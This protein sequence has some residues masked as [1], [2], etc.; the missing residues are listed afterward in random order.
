V[1]ENVFRGFS[2]KRHIR[3][4]AAAVAGESPE[5]VLSY[6]RGQV[7]AKQLVIALR[8]ASNEGA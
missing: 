1:T 3:G 5:I 4:A 8:G 2:K 7:G 6:A